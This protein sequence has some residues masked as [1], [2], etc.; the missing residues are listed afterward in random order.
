VLH[1]VGPLSATVYWRRRLL[2]L[3]C[4]L[5]VVG[6]GGWVTTAAL[7]S[8][9]DDGTAATA[10]AA[11]ATPVLDQVMPSLTAVD[12]PSTTPP[13][14]ES[15]ASAAA[16]TGPAEGGP[17]SDDMISVEVRSDPSATPAGS[18]PTFHLVVTNI[19]SVSCVRPLDKGLQEIVL[20]DGA[21]TRL[22]GS[23]DCFPEASSDARTLAPGEAVDFPVL[24]SGLGS[25]PGCAGDRTQ[26]APG[27]YVLRARLDTKT[28]PDAALTLS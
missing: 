1:P 17:C 5:G 20:L 3:G 24:W 9:P 18:E 23:N 22:W 12:L 21:G 8:G 28:S 11:P 7:G 15:A 13:S 2:V 19:A 26:L 10:A 6:G 27:E 25:Q 14:A 4:T 16:T